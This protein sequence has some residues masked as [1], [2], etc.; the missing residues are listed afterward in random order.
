MGINRKRKQMEKITK[1]FS[2]QIVPVIKIVGMIGTGSKEDPVSMGEQYWSLDGKVI[3]TLD[4][5]ERPKPSDILND[6]IP[7]ESKQKEEL[8]K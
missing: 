1:V 2:A 5:R 3:A 6:I 7:F 4:P 8:K